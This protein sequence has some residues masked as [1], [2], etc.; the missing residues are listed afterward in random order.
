MHFF[1]VVLIICLVVF[2]FTLYTF[3]HDDFIL[4]R[5]DVS[6]DQVFNL[7]LIASALSLLSSRV[8]YVLMH[9]KPVFLNPLGFIIFPY[10][11]G[12]SF[13]GGIVGGL[14]LF[15][16]LLRRRGFPTGRI[17]DFFSISFL[18]A[19]P[20][21]FIGYML[22]SRNFDPLIISEFFIYLLL[23]LI[24]WFILIPRFIKNSRQDGL[25]GLIFLLSVS[26]IATAHNLLARTKILNVENIASLLIFVGALM[27]IVRLILKGRV[28]K[29]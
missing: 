28:G 4:L 6:M 14:I 1:A 5:R 2:L 12:L 7:A 15:I 17:F 19:L 16:I 13:I 11:P 20:I 29:K 9:P 18:S 27:I 26:F 25:L 10:F 24:Y 23:L 22:L 21:G 3:S 8:F